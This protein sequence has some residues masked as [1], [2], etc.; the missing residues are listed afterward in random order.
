MVLH[1]ASIAQGWMAQNRLGGVDVSFKDSSL[2][3]PTFVASGAVALVGCFV[4]GRRTLLFRD[5]DASSMDPSSAG[6]TVCGYFFVL[7]G[8]AALALPSAVVEEMQPSTDFDV[9]LVVNAFMAVSLGIFIVV[10]LHLMFR[11]TRFNYWTTLKCLQGGL[12]GFVAIAA[13]YDLYTPPIACL[14][15]SLAVVTFY[16][17]SELVSW[18]ALEDNCNIIATYFVC[19][20]FSCLSPPIFGHKENLGFFSNNNVY[21]NYIHFAWQLLC[22]AVVVGIF[23]IVFLIVFLCLLLFGFLKNDQEI[24]A[25]ARAK[26][27]SKSRKKKM[28]YILP[29]TERHVETQAN[30]PEETNSHQLPIKI[31]RTKGVFTIQHLTRGVVGGS[32][33]IRM[34]PSTANQNRK[35]SSKKVQVRTAF[36]KCKN[37]VVR[38]PFY[39]ITV[40]NV[41]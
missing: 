28:G 5:L 29:N 25:H 34:A 19:G 22:C 27:V 16:V 40:L 31:P 33:E 12:A 2:V 38:N 26:R 39:K 7:V 15:T 20:I 1:S 8:T 30:K 23:V 18:S 36:R 14:V 3:L 32:S 21:V 37:V 4:L 41:E 10:L 6:T 17:T 13:G 11:G 9:I 24:L 35:T